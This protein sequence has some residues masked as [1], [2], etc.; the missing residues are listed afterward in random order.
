MRNDDPEMTMARLSVL[1]PAEQAVLDQALTGVP[2]RD[3]A[4][5]LSLS[6]ATV[7]SHLSSIY[8]KLGVS[9]RVALLAHFRGSDA[10]PPAVQSPTLPR[11]R[12]VSIAGW[13]WGALAVLEGAYAIYLASGALASGGTQETWVL[14][15][16]FGILAA[17]VARLSREILQQPSPRNMLVAVLVAAGHLLFAIRGIFLSVPDAPFLVLGALALAMVGIS[18]R[19]IRGLPER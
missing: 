10:P 19:A 9:G 14:A 12:G 15:I 1:T 11:S 8:V 13:G 4:E 3:I 5:H 6:E 7:R 17:F 2:A 18:F 16:G